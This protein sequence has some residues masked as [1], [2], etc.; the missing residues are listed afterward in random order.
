MTGCADCLNSGGRSETISS[1]SSERSRGGRAATPR[2][3]ATAA[4][5]S[6]RK[7]LELVADD[8]EVSYLANGERQLAIERLLIRFGET[9][10]SIPSETLT[11]I[12]AKIA[13]A[14]PK[15]FRDISI[16]RDQ[17]TPRC[18]SLG[19]SHCG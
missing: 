13:W 3:A 2:G 1:V 18:A 19:A 15:G 10:K 17:Q 6:G 16:T 7:A 5:R 8:N 4:V 12:D 9:L 14:G 11:E